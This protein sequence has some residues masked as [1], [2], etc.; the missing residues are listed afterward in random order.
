MTTL[1]HTVTKCDEGV[2]R[3]T[4]GPTSAKRIHSTAD[5]NY[6]LKHAV[7]IW[8]FLNPLQSALKLGTRLKE[9]REPDVLLS[10]GPMGDDSHSGL[11]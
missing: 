7:A 6:D 2:P 3:R 8:A 1:V 4:T 9:V 5:Q 10:D 11:R